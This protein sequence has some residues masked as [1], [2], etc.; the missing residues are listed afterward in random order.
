MNSACQRSLQVV[1]RVSVTARKLGAG[2]AENGFHIHSSDTS[3]EECGGDPQVGNT[4]IRVGKAVGN[5][6]TI[7]PGLIDGGSV[8]RE[9]EVKRIV[10]GRRCWRSAVRIRQRRAGCGRK[11]DSVASGLYQRRAVGGKADGGMQKFHPGRPSA[12][13]APL[14]LLIGESGQSSQIAPV[15]AGS[16]CLIQASQLSADF[17]RHGRFQRLTADLNPGLEMARA[18]LNHHAGWVP[19]GPHVIE[20]HWVT[21][22]QIEQNKASIPPKFIGLEIDVKALA[23]PGAQKSYSGAMGD[24]R[25][26]PKP[27]SREGFSGVVMNQTNQIKIARHRREL[28]AQ[29]LQG[30][31]KSAIHDRESNMHPPPVLSKPD[32]STLQRIGHFYFALTRSAL[33]LTFSL[34]AIILCLSFCSGH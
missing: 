30:E 20:D 8:G 9:S 33:R 22:V 2:Q 12:R 5:A 29:S 13:Q 14:R 15:G 34:N 10:R 26:C 21:V 11:R 16:V 31:K 32:I 19:I 24:L 18:G 1:L 4:P 27:V 28:S 17:G 3:G 6:Q 25:R 7:Q 23:I